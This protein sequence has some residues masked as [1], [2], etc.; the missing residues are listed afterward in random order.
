MVSDISR[1]DLSVV[2]GRLHGNKPH[3]NDFSSGRCSRE[4]PGEN[5]SEEKQ[6]RSNCR[7]PASPGWSVG[8]FRRI[9][10]QTCGD[11]IAPLASWWERFT[12]ASVF[13]ASTEARSTIRAISHLCLSRLRCRRGDVGRGSYERWE[14]GTVDDA[15]RDAAAGGD[16]ASRRSRLELDADPGTLLSS[17]EFPEF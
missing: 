7:S 13:Y 15:E 11:N 9:S 14:A 12:S 16:E 2:Y 6:T 8:I 10:D 5:R 1:F 4:F 3:F 17:S